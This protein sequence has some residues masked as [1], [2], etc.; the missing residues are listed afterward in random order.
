M[1]SRSVARSRRC[2]HRFPRSFATR[3]IEQQARE[4]DVRR[5]LGHSTSAMLRR[6][7]AFYDPEKAAQA[8]SLFSPG[9][10]LA[11]LTSA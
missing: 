6:H 11:E 8:H 5:L 3:A 7:T 10:R 1:I 4:I 9:D 2:T